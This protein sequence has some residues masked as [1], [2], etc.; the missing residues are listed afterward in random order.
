MAA[1]A[2]DDD[3]F[4][5]LHDFLIGQ[6][7]INADGR[8]V[9][10]ERER[11]R[12]EAGTSSSTPS[13]CIAGGEKSTTMLGTVVNSCFIKMAGPIPIAPADSLLGRGL[14]L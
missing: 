10:C 3:L 9:N 13:A 5:L 2:Y 11:T 7:W 12:F 14:L 6:F 1:P 4:R 8:I